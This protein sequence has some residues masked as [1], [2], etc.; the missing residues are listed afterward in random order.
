MKK[1]A[2]LLALPLTMWGLFAVITHAD[3]A[4]DP[5]LMS[6]ADVVP[7]DPA[8]EALAS[9]TANGVFIPRDD[10]GVYFAD[11]DN[12]VMKDE[13]AQFL[14]RVMGFSVVDCTVEK[15]VDLGIL[16]SV[17]E[18][19]PLDNAT[20]A[21]ILG[22][23][24]GVKTGSGTGDNWA[25]APW[26]VAKGTGAF[27]NRKSG[28]V[29]TWRDMLIATKIFEDNF[30]LQTV[31]QRMVFLETKLME[32]RDGFLN[33][34]AD[35]FELEQLI[36]NNIMK[37]EEIEMNNRLAAIKYLNLSFVHMLELRKNTAKA[38]RQ[39]EIRLKYAN[40]FLDLADAALPE[41]KPFTDDL[42]K[43]AGELLI[44]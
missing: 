4:L 27:A 17:P 28:N 9:Y 20:S 5:S 11:L 32:I 15:V 1:I 13:A 24:F 42:R 31:E 7:L 19:V 29:T 33:P 8:Y 30:G 16:K 2:L 38:E 44:Q 18:S 23:A 35:L 41:V 12:A 43:I 26:I 21:V 22:K 40:T 14:C 37:A 6:Y 25:L 34:E 36:W 3:N 10:E 39:K